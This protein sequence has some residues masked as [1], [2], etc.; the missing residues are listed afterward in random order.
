MFLN[1]FLLFGLSAVSVPII[2][3]LLN[4][5]QFQHVVWAAMRFIQQAVEKNQ[6]RMRIEDLILL[7]LR[8]LIL[9][10]IALALSRPA[11][12][13]MA[14]GLGEGTVAA[15]IVLDNSYSLS[16]R[17]GPTNRFEQAKSAAD[18]VLD[19][20]P[21]GSSVAFLLA[22]DVATP[23]IGEPT[24]DRD[25]VR[26]AIQE[27]TR[28]DRGTNMVPAIQRGLATLSDHAAVRKELYIITD[29]Q[30]SGWRQGTD[31]QRLL[32]ENRHA[33]STNI[34]FVGE[35]T[36]RNVGVSDLRLDSDLAVA[37]QSLR[38]VAGV[39][40]Y[41]PT[42]VSDVEVRLNLDD[43][44]VADVGHTGELTAGQT[45]TVALSGKIRTEGYHAATVRI[46]TDDIPADDARSLALH[47]IKQ[48]HVLLVD[49]EP[50]L[51]PRDSK[52]YY[53]RHALQPIDAAAR[54]NYFV[55]VTN[56]PLAEFAAQ[57][58][59]NFDAVM[60]ANVAELPAADVT[61]VERFIKA[62]GGLVVFPGPNANVPFYNQQL[63]AKRTLLPASI[64]EARGDA[65]QAVK[66][67][68]FQTKDFQHPI[69]TI[70]NQTD[71]GTPATVQFYRAY[72]LVAAKTPSAADLA[73]DPNPGPPRVVLSFNDG[74]P[75]IMERTYGLGRV[76]LFAHGADTAWTDLPVRAKVY[77]PL[78]MRVVGSLVS[79]EDEAL[80][81][82]VGE[83]L[84]RQESADEAGR[85]VQITIPGEDRTAPASVRI[86]LD[87]AGAARF[88]FDRTDRAGVYT[89]L[90][91]P[92][93]SNFIKFATTPN[94]EE[95]HIEPIA[96]AQ[97]KSLSAV[98]NVVTW[99]PGT[100][101][102]DAVKQTRTGR[103][104]WFT[105]ALIALALAAGETFLAHLFSR[106]K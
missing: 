82:R 35:M 7:I 34:I 14:G 26:K 70:W 2:I 80:N 48:V 40:N 76:V 84:V 43:D 25:A 15:V 29:S 31:I 87:A 42:T 28:S 5:R 57:R 10:L 85:E 22:S 67:R 60:L 91:G 21:Q 6:R 18:R 1:P 16:Q 90:I 27:A 51:E 98:A 55:Q 58:L 12:K 3:H 71:R 78:M 75:A 47:V 56:I 73:K 100:E 68:T 94:T 79:R 99:K 24:A 8:C 50:T 49:G 83:R 30:A 86:E 64:G 45:K 13:H 20:L 37:G 53:L 69:A 106:P 23:V 9:A 32:E 88:V 95:S 36:T 81:I 93:P 11:L 61:A 33:A 44:P 92:T 103:E 96:S 46:P 59:N 105:L 19:S 66:F 52:T 101:L 38:F 4:R 89:A 65:G 77:L 62:G 17:D 102:D 104:F 74:K 97:L 41:S 54:E 39:T 63:L 72:D